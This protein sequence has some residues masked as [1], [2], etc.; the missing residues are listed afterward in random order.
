MQPAP[1]DTH[2][3]SSQAAAELAADIGHR[4]AG[5]RAGL[6]EAQVVDLQP[7]DFAVLPA[8]DNRL[9][10]LLR[11]DTDLGPGVMG[12]G[13]Q[14]TG[15]V[16]HKHQL[17]GLAFGMA[18]EQLIDQAASRLGNSRVQQRGRGDDQNGAGLELASGSWRQQQAEVAVGDPA[19]LQD[20]PECVPAE[21]VHCRTPAFLTWRLRDQATRPTR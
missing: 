4:R 1:T 10:D 14:L 18:G 8:A 20:F 15:E 9:G 19:R 7:S 2:E 5:Q 13:A 17:P 6:L 12:P 21:L 3:P 11:V 16:G